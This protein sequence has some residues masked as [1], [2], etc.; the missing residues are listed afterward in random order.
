MTNHSNYALET[1][2][3]AVYYLAVG[4]GDVRKRLKTAYMEFHPISE[5]DFPPNLREDWK[6]IIK[7]L[8]RYGPVRRSNGAVWIG[9]ADNT[10]SRIKNSTGA[11]IA[12]RIVALEAELRNHLQDG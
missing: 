3:H 4:G 8:T 12:Q 10:L 2:G 5:D 6:W 9:A 11:K 7:Q 1:L